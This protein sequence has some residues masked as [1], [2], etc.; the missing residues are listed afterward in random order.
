MPISYARSYVG[1]P[2]DLPLFVYARAVDHTALLCSLHAV[3][4]A[5]ETVERGECCVLFGIGAGRCPC[6]NPTLHRLLPRRTNRQSNDPRARD[7]RDGGR[8]CPQA[9]SGSR[10]R[11]RPAHRTSRYNR[12]KTPRRRSPRAN[13]LQA[14]QTAQAPQ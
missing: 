10:P 8:D 6:R 3:G 1:E 11:C 4:I 5:A 12:R 7:L 14:P 9:C 13:R 2:S